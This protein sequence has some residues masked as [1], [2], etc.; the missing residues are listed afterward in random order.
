MAKEL[1]PD[2]KYLVNVRESM[3]RMLKTEDGKMSMEFLESMVGWEFPL[4]AENIHKAN[5]ARSVV[6][7]MKNITKETPVD[8]F[9]DHCAKH[10]ASGKLVK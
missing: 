3:S 7:M 1:T 8:N 6:C 10:Y 9:L 5:G 4:S 2:E